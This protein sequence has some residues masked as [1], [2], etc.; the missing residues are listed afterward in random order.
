MRALPPWAMV[1]RKRGPA[2]REDDSVPWLR[3]RA[4]ARAVPQ[5][6]DSPTIGGGTDGSLTA[7]RQYPTAV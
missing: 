7:V 5:E 4:S 2:T 3:G 1:A 6:Q